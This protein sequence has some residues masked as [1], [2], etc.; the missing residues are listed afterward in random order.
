MVAGDWIKMR[1]DLRDDPAVISVAAALGIDEDAV[2]GKLH[3]FWSWADQHT[4]DGCA[5]SNAAAVTQSWLDR[6]VGAP[7]FSAALADA[8]WLTI[9]DSCIS[10]PKFDSHN[11]ETGK[12]R[13]LTARRAAKRR[14]GECANSNANS[15]APG[16]T[17]SAPRSESEK[18]SSDVSDAFA[19]VTEQTLRDDTELAAWHSR[20]SARPRPVVSPSEAGL[21][22]VFAAAERAI[23]K[24][25]EP[26]R[27]FATMFRKGKS[28]DISN[29]DQDRARSRLTAMQSRAP[30]EDVAAMLQGFGKHQ[31]GDSAP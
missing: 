30:P 5:K 13:S 16:V 1:T 20:V 4:V 25:R 12:R 15:N 6:Y 26:V 17:K 8:G 3:R 19:G 11:G 28:G 24:G 14:A 10:I 9:S 21:L 23:A 7:G 27:L 2:V 18:T 31:N 22:F 29:A